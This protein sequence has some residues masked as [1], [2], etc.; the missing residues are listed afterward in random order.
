MSQQT[1]NHLAGQSSPYLLQHLYNP[2]DWYP[3]GEEAFSRARDDDKPI[4]LSIGYSACHWCHVMERESFESASIAVLLNDN[5]VSIKVDRE[6]LPD[7][8]DVYMTFVQAY[9]G[10]GGW[11]LSAF[12]APNLKPFFGGTYF[13]PGDNY[14]RPGFAH[15]LTRI[16]ELW[17]T[18]RQQ[19]LDN[20]EHIS[21]TL[22][23]QSAVAQPDGDIALETATLT[24]AGQELLDSFDRKW[25][26][27][28]DA[29]KFPSAASIQILLREYQRTHD[30]NLLHAATHTLDCM[31]YGG[32]YDQLGGGFARYSVDDKWLVPHFEKMLYDNALLVAAYIEAWQ[33]T[34][35]I[36]YQRIVRETLD[37]ILRD[38]TDDSGGFH[39]AEDADS[40]GVEGK[41]YVWDKSEIETV[42][43]SESAELFTSFYGITAGGNFEGHNILNIPVPPSTFA[44]SRDLTTDELWNRIGDARDKL[45]AVREQRVRPGKDH[46]VLTCWN[47]LMI[48]AMARAAQVLDDDVYR[49]AAI[50]AAAFIRDTMTNDTGL[51]HVYCNGTARIPGYVDDYAAAALAFM[52]VY[53]TD[54]DPAWLRTA[55]E[56]IDSMI[57]RFWSAESSAFYLAEEAHSK[58]FLRSQPNYDGAVPAGNSL[59]AMALLR[60]SHFCDRSDY[61]EIAVQVLRRNY[62]AMKTIPRGFMNLLLALDFHLY[63]PAEIA[64]IGDLQDEAAQALLRTVHE[65]FLP[66]RLLAFADSANDQPLLH[67]KAMIDDKATAFV[68]RNF[69]CDK[70]TTE[71]QELAR[72]LTS[73]TM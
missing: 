23:E 34:G 69:V 22:C 65:R 37:Y 9:T 16:A 26:G 66:S 3:W 5:F 21:S 60:S 32:M 4:F 72:Q 57:K 33:V 1:P 58:L 67:G 64:I 40:E 49:V 10:S 29:P 45:M 17:K 36:E 63:L 52:D 20:A 2:V 43:D 8:D 6:E 61:R 14:G 11:P 27:F 30:D 73:L 31:A 28:G 41:F 35:N 48:S 24:A 25:G 62:D 42:L 70:P 46:K 44:A 55:A 38:M 53:E 50:R 71:V 18:E 39:A 12:L 54:G 13:P 56:L 59:A 51:L 19:V 15:I 7:V 68:C 47:G